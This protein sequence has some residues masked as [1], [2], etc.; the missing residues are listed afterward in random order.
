MC[1]FFLAFEFLDHNDGAIFEVLHTGPMKA[2]VIKGVIVDL[3]APIQ[4]SLGSTAPKRH[5]LAWTGAAV[6]FSLGALGMFESIA[7][8]KIDSFLPELFDPNTRVLV[9]RGAEFLA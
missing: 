6:A 5:Q 7:G 4:F 1:F 9:A 8:V 3:T 2:P